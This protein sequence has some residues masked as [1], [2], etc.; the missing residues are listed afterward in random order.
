MFELEQDRKTAT[1]TTDSGSLTVTYRPHALTPAKELAMLRVPSEAIDEDADE[2]AQNEA[3]ERANQSISMQLNSFC[4]LV[5]AW[6]FLGPLAQDAE[7]N[8]L[9][10]PRG[11]DSIEQ[12]AYAEERGG[13]V[14]VAE[15]EMVPLQPRYLKLISSHLLMQ[16]VRGINADM[17]PNDKRQRR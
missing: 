16:V 11:L 13:Q 17:R 8:Y 14:V 15:G 2:D 4:E 5:E 7:G 6:D 3:Y 9:P 1:I 12:Q 10:L